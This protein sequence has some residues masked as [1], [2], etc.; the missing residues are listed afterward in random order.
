MRKTRIG[1]L[2]ASTALASATVLGGAAVANAST[3]DVLGSLDV[4][5]SLF[6]EAEEPTEPTE[7]DFA[8]IV[9]TSLNDEPRYTMTATAYD[10]C[11]VAFTLSDDWP[12]DYQPNFRADYRVGEE[13][14]V[15]PGSSRG[16]ET[17]RPVLGS[18][19]AVADAIENRPNE[20]NF[21][22]NEDTVDLTADR[23]VPDYENT[24]EVTTLPGVAPNED[25]THVITFGVYQGPDT[26]AHGYYSFDTTVTVTGCPTTEDEDDSGPLGSLDVFGSLES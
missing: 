6:P 4:G 9:G 23:V 12:G 25:G 24:S 7:V 13:A 20:Y 11:T 16:D 18:N 1:A 5:G 2:L 21:A 15:M 14:P 10:N 22:A 3:E 26:A 8:E 17:Y 19:Q